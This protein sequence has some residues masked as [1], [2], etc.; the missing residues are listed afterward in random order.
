MRI[1]AL[2]TG[3]STVALVAAF[4][5]PQAAAEP[6]QRTYEVTVTNL[7][8]GQPLTPPVVATHLGAYDAFDVGSPASEAV[9]QIAENGDGGPL[10]A[11]LGSSKHV[12]AFLQTGTGPLVPD[13]LAGSGMFAD[14]VTFEIT[15][16]PGANFL[17]YVSMLICTNDGFT[18]ADA[19][20]LPNQVGQTAT[21]ATFAYDAGTEINTEDLA[22][23][24]PPCQ[25]LVG[26]TSGDAGTGMTNPALA[27]GGVIHHHG[28]VAGIADLVPGVH[29]WDTSAPVAEISVT[30]TA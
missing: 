18:G 25:A 21:A 13:G 9:Q 19:L 15:A 26:V 24:V 4:A 11:E 20:K 16:G 30:R 28:G 22:D 12:D 8:G 7:T 10:L 6:T 3:I 27:E 29:G 14:A 5:V 17:S 1:R 23:I 2:M